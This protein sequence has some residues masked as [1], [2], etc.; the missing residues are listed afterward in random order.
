M[1]K[2][3]L[4]IAALSYCSFNYAQ[5]NT[6][7]ASGNAGIGTVTPDPSSILDM[8]SV[9]QGLLVPRMTMAQRDSIVTPA[10]GLLLYQTDSTA[11][12]VFYDGTTWLPITC[13]GA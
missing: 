5:T 13:N 1:K 4:L 3:F 7:P 9:T 6:F 12:F 10:K 8:G 2:I 11:G